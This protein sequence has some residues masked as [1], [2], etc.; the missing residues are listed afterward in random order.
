MRKSTDKPNIILMNCDDLG[1][2]DLACTGHPQH[3]TPYLDRMA[4]EGTRFTD[5]YQGSP[6]CSPSRGAMLTGCYP[7][8]IGFDTFEG[9]GVLFP[10]QGVGLNPSE[11]TFA[12]LLKR[13]GYATQ[14]IG[15]WHCGDQPAF[16]PTRHGFDAYYGIPFSND[17]GRQVGR[18][19]TPPLPLLRDE[20]VIE[21]Q[22]DQAGVTARY[23]EEA[24]RFIRA[25]R[26]EPFLLYFAHMYVHLP[27]YV[28]ERFR[29]ESQNGSYGAAVACI[30]WAMGVLLDALRELGLD[31]NTIVMFTSDNGSRCDYGPS[32][33]S[34]HGRKGTCWEGGQRVPFL[35]RWPG[36][37]AAGAVCSEV[38]TGMDLLP[39]FARLAGAKIP[40]DR[41]IDGR[42]IVP[43]LRGEA[44]ARSPHRA[45]YYYILDSLNAVRAGRWKLHVSRRKGWGEPGAANLCELYDLQ[46]DPGETVDVAERHPEVVRELQA[47]ADAARA[48]LG[49]AVTNSPGADHRPIGRVD[50]PKPLTAFDPEHPYYIA[51]Y[52]LK[53]IG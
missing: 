32:N 7:R 33:G 28:Q 40:D 44:A 14:I 30:D 12:S 16:L 34:L 23:V 41:T 35:V 6:I 18:E 13:Q 31:Q 11:I 10:G 3:R 21:E 26:D 52:D 22:P 9:R 4:S 43:L 29:A 17:M 50:N 25:H 42:D 53:E 48:D 45:F 8:R 20:K 2:G 1:F 36:Q 46:S 15:K 38:V 49:D 27:I 19:Q 51:L 37:V 24:V 5:F 39:T 47:L